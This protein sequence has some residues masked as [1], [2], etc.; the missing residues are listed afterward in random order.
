MLQLLTEGTAAAT[1]DRFFQLLARHAAQALGARYAFAA[2]TLSP[3]ESR[4]LAYWEGSGFGEGFSYRF[5][6]TPCQRVAQGH[7]CMTCTGL[8]EAFPEDIWLQQIGVDS[9]VGV[10]MRIASGDVIG[11]L[12][13][14]HTEP[15]QPSREAMAILQIF[16]SRGAAELQRMQTD[17]ELQKAL[18]EVERLRDRLQAENVYLQDEI[19]AEHNFEELIGTSEP[20]RQLMQQVRS[21]AATDSTVLVAGETGVGKELIARALHFGSSR[22]TRPLVKVN[23]AAISA[24]L[25]ESE[26]FGH[27]KGA[28]TGAFEKRVGRF[29]LANG[30]TIFLDEIGELPLES[31]VRLL[32]VLQEQEFEPVGSS[33][34]QRV[35]A[36]VIAAT[37]RNLAECVQNGTFRA[38]LF[39]RLNVIPLHVPPLRERASDIAPL[40][41]H[42]LA[43][44]T[45]KTGKPIHGI[46]TAA[47]DQMLC[48]EWPGNVRELENLI[49]RAV[50]LSTGP[51]LDLKSVF[52]SQPPLTPRVNAASKPAPPASEP[53]S[54]AGKPKSMEEV[55][56]A[57]LLSVLEATNWVIEGPRGAAQALNVSPSTMRSRMKRL[58]IERGRASA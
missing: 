37:N 15:M 2:E 38:D 35:D 47:L 30:G 49:E 23:C 45:R 26:L 9:Y 46:G 3:H 50:V 44:A 55:E 28:F 54:H 13:V 1:G 33:A 12:A 6:G 58:G 4:S 36:R 10:P 8:R 24:G 18:A 27:V 31:Q 16:A 52:P 25:V 7:V 17:R 40:A 32:R 51:A 42:F 57:H 21:V 29:E 56:R 34:T 41:L 20:W 39:F 48:Y 22:R 43:R 11:H 14:L 5:P 19:R 53:P